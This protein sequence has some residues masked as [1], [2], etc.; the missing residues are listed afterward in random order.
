MSEPTVSKCANPE[1]NT[2]FRRLGEGRLFVRPI[3][4]TEGANRLKQK[5][6]WL[7]DECSERYDLRFDWRH[8]KFNVVRNHRAA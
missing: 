4:N 7:C 5:A 1:C 2:E 8:E 6:A 3:K